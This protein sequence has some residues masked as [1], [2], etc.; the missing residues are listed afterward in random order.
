AALTPWNFPVVGPARKVG[1]SLAAG[2]TCVLKPAEESPAS[3]LEL[4]SA[5]FDAGLPDGVLSIVGGRPAESSQRLLAAPAIRKLSFTGSVPVGKQLLA[6]AADTITR[7]TMELG[8]HA[9]VVVLDDADLDVALAH[10]VF[11]K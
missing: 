4:A 7:T 2:C 3:A 8:G 10:S 5:L 9:P 6:L 1:P 11:M